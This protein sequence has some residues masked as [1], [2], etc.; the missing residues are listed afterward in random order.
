MTLSI[1]KTLNNK[2]NTI[3]Y[4]LNLDP[5][6]AVVKPSDRP[7]LSDFQCNG[8]LAQAKILHKNPREIAQTI[9][10][11]LQND[12]DIAAVSIDGPGFII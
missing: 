5:R 4:K 3:F 9:V 1:E 6:F 7:D 11:E 10:N 2:L 12:A 8:A